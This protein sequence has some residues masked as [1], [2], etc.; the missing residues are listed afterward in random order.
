MPLWFCQVLPALQRLDQHTPRDGQMLI[1]AA[2]LDLRNL[3]R[4]LPVRLGN[5]P[6]SGLAHSTTHKFGHP[7]LNS[8][9]QSCPF[10]Q[11]LDLLYSVL[12]SQQTKRESE[13]HSISPTWISLGTILSLPMFIILSQ[14]HPRLQSK[15]LLGQYGIIC[16]D[17]LG[18]CSI[19]PSVISSR[20][21]HASA[22]CLPVEN[23][24]EFPNHQIAVQPL[25]L[26]F[27]FSHA[28]FVHYGSLCSWCI[29][30]L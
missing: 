23:H 6:C 21:L 30:L 26:F 11:F 17:L 13:L 22:L 19:K 12:V 16:Y 24:G 3:P 9:V 14:A 20:W 4:M 15:R 18:S 27:R 25:I 7:R 28:Q 1:S 2:L 29:F 5:Q 10:V 8:R